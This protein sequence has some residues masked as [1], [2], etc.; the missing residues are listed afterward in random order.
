MKQ[1][2]STPRGSPATSP[3]GPH[4]IG[5]RV[6]DNTALAYPGSGQPNLTNAAFSSVNVK[7]GCICNLAARAK[8][9]KIQLTW[10]PLAGATSYD[11]YRS[12]LGPNTGFAKIKA[13]LVSS[14]ATYLDGAVTVGTKYWYR[15]M[16]N[17][18][19]GAAAC[20]SNASSA[21]PTLR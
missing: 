16:A 19:A 20:G 14:Y 17:T 21:T 3:P 12:T 15:V 6:S 5:L 4:T 10:T 2:S 9:T 13:N 1:L 7:T 11:I 18:A 8:L